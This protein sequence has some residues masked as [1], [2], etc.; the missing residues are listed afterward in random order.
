[1]SIRP[2]EPRDPNGPPRGLPFSR[3]G[4]LGLVLFCGVL[5]LGVVLLEGVRRGG[6][7]PE[8]GASGGAAAGPDDAP[9]VFVREPR[10]EFLDDAD[11]A[12]QYPTTVREELEAELTAW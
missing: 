10:I 12:A 4:P 8:G 1:M 11:L 5:L 9:D 2:P 6:S 3:V 7:A